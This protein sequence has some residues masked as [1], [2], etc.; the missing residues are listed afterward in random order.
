MFNWFT[1]KPNRN[2]KL[3]LSP[4]KSGMKYAGFHS[5]EALVL[6]G[7]QGETIS[8]L[9]QRFNQ[10]RGPDEQIGSLFTKDGEHL[11]FMTVIYEDMTAI[12]RHK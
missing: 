4:D 9:M 8:D 7:I 5:G 12:V 1:S 10:Y 3:T 11:S 2:V 6:T